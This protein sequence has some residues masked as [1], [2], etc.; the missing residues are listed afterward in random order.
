MEGPF[1][2][3]DDDEI[4]TASHFCGNK[5]EPLSEAK[6]VTNELCLGKPAIECRTKFRDYEFYA[7]EPERLFGRKFDFI[8]SLDKLGGREKENASPK[9]RKNKNPKRT[10]RA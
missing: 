5:N 10:H 6:L 1:R 8:G 4:V 3:L 2:I 7:N 9:K